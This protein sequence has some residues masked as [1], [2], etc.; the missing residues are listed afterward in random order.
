MLGNVIIVSH[1]KSN[2]NTYERKSLIYKA[3]LPAVESEKADSTERVR[4]SLPRF[5][6]YGC[7]YRAYT[8][9]I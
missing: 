4:I 5:Y 9:K 2:F 3:F 1:C 7:T 8:H 6:I